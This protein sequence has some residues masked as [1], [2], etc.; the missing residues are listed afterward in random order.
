MAWQIPAKG[1]SSRRPDAGV[2]GGPGLIEFGS[3]DLAGPLRVGVLQYVES[4]VLPWGS[5]PASCLHRS[6]LRGTY[7]LVTARSAT[8]GRASL[9]IGG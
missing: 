8:A 3:V 2:L 9:Y 7:G 6:T 1:S 5:N 4:V